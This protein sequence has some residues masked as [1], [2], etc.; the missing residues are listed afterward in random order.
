M[1]HFILSDKLINLSGLKV[2]FAIVFKNEW[3]E[4]T[5]LEPIWVE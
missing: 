2:N 4:W 3:M 5:K 1:L